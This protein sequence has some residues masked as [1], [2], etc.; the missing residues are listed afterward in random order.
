MSTIL[1]VISHKSPFQFVCLFVFPNIIPLGLKTT[2]KV[3]V[4]ARALLFFLYR[5]GPP[6]GQAFLQRSE[7]RG[8]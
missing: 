4:R 2:E 3:S 5:E 6:E 8:M 7:E 1:R